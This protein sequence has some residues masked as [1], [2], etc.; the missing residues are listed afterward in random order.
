MGRPNQNCNHGMKITTSIINQFEQEQKQFG[1]KI[2]LENI[3]WQV[4]SGLMKN[5]GVKNIKTSYK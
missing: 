4:A 1:T 3:L 5:I 2:A